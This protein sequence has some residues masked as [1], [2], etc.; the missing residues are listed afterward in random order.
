MSNSNH[1][2]LVTQAPLS[3]QV[4][5]TNRATRRDREAVINHLHAAGVGG[6]RIRRLQRAWI[7]GEH[8]KSNDESRDTYVAR[9]VAL[10]KTL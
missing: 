1:R 9:M 4:M 2:G 7:A 6:K 3:T 5:E 10:V 8:A